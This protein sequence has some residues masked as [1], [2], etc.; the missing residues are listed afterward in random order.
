MSIVA[1]WSQEEAKTACL[2]SEGS[3]N[4]GADID[5]SFGG[6]GINPTPHALPVGVEPN[7]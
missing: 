1:T 6:T 7:P 3:M 4:W 2:I 5:P